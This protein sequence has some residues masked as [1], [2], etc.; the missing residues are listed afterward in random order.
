MRIKLK[1]CGIKSL[2]NAIDVSRMGVDFIGFVAEPSS[3]RYVPEDVISEAK[4]LIETTPIVYVKASGSIED[5]VKN[6]ADF[7]QIHR[8]LEDR[9]LDTLQTYN[10]KFILYVPASLDYIGY[11]RKVQRYSDYVLFDSPTK[12]VRSDPRILKTLLD[13]H[14]DAGVAGGIT[15]DNVYEYLQLEP[16]WI[17]VSSGVEVAPG[18]KDLNKVR[19]LK[20]VVHSWRRRL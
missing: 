16:G 12:G 5:M 20:E 6:S 8:V 11:L 17:D 3:P 7:I 1:I 10:R 4:K 9:E 19:I 13:Y 15:I 2:Q 14:S 18:I